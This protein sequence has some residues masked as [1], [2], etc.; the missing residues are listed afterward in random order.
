VTYYGGV[1]E[2]YGHGIAVYSNQVYVSGLTTGSSQNVFASPLQ[3]SPNS[4]VSVTPGYDRGFIARFNSEFGNR[5]WGTYFGGS[6]NFYG[7]N[8]IECDASGNVFVVG[9]IFWNDFTLSCMPSGANTPICNPGGG[10][11]VQQYHAAGPAPWGVDG[12]IAKFNNNTELVWSTFFGGSGND[13]ISNL[14][15][16]NVNHKLYVVGHSTSIRVGTP[17]C[18]WVSGFPDTSFPLCDGGGYFQT[19]LNGINEI[20]GINDGFIARFT[21]GGVLEWSTFFGGFYD[22]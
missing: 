12:F 5:E 19:D 15:I 8:Q 2:D 20:N 18:A 11:Y 9:S 3:G 16:D 21:L 17:T 7:T 4:F 22:F 14:A 1:G 13:W 6:I 10:A